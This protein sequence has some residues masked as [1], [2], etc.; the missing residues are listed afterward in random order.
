MKLADI[1]QDKP[2]PPSD[3]KIRMLAERASKRQP[4]FPPTLKPEDA[5]EFDHY[6]RIKEVHQA[7]GYYLSFWKVNEHEHDSEVVFTQIA[8]MLLAD[9]KRPARYTQELPPPESNP[10]IK[11]SKIVWKW[12]SVKADIRRLMVGMAIKEMAGRL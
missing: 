12:H 7:L 2:R 4:L 10:V 6:L 5:L 9:P 1:D 8:K 11:T 3:E